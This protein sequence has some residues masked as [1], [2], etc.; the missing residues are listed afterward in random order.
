MKF[1]RIHAKP[2]DPAAELAKA[3]PV[4]GAAI[5]TF[6]RKVSKAAARQQR[7]RVRRAQVSGAGPARHRLAL[8]ARLRTRTPVA[9]VTRR[10]SS[11]DGR[12]GSAGVPTVQAG[13]EHATAALR[14]Q[15][16]AFRAR[17]R[18]ISECANG[19]RR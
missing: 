17:L 9:L 2:L 12:R 6:D 5:E 4:L 10:R 8:P 7:R 3:A 1:W 18:R 11:A 13:A 15:L 16:R 19:R 14:G